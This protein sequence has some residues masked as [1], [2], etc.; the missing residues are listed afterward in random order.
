[1]K[2]NIKYWSGDVWKTIV[3]LKAIHD[4]LSITVLNCDFGVGIIRRGINKNKIDL[5][6]DEIKELDYN[7]LNKNRTEIL[8]L[9]N[10]NYLH[11]ILKDLK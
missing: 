3:A 11:T 8:N 5:T 2:E 10:P 7:Y 4:D 1:M 6:Y 9:K